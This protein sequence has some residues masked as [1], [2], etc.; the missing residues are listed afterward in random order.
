MTPDLGRLASEQVHELRTAESRWLQSA[1]DRLRSG[2]HSD[3]AGTDPR[4][5]TSD[6]TEEHQ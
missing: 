1:R 6:D 3:T 2:R 4:R 5:P